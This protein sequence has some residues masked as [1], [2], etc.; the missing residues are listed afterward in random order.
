MK[1]RVV[2]PLPPALADLGAGQDTRFEMEIYA[3]FMRHLR[4]VPNSRMEI[5]ILSAIQFTAD[6]LET[7]DALV[8][9]TLVDLGLKAPRKA[10]PMS[11]LDFCDKALLR[12]DWDRHDGKG[13]PPS[14][15]LM[16]KEHWDGIGEEKP[17]PFPVHYAV[18]GERLLLN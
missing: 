11:F 6:M 9:K 18:A 4:D 16:L 2:L 13:R 3:R 1:E 10:F 12:R 14:A 7:P 17:S 8:A 5:K 15:V